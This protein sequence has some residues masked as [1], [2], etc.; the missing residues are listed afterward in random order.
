MTPNCFMATIDLK[1]AYYSVPVNVNHRRYLRFIWK[2]QLFQYTCLPN[3]LSSAPRLFTKILKPLYATLRSQGFE[4]VGYIDDS[5]LQGGTFADCDTNVAVTANLF[6]NLGFLLNHEK[7][8]FEPRQIITFLGFVLNAAAMTVALTPGKA[9]K[10]V[11]KAKTILGKQSP[12]IREVSELIGLM[13]SSF[14]GVMH[15][16]L[17]YRQRLTKQW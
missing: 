5:Y 13:V 6:C 11:T 14:P 4:N 15:G 16:P 3:G 17:F 10:L 7:S 8:V 9:S 12:F 1:D 2:N